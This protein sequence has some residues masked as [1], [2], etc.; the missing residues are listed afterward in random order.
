IED[1]RAEVTI[2]SESVAVEPGDA[3]GDV[4][5]LVLAA[6][7]EDNKLD[8]DLD[9]KAPA[10]GVIVAMAGLDGPLEAKLE[11]QGTWTDWNG[12]LKASWLAQ[13]LAD[14]AL[15]ARSGT[16]RAVGNTQ[17][18]GLAPDSLASALKGSSALEAE[19]ELADAST[20]IDA[21]LMGN[22]IRFEASGNV[23]LAENRFDGLRAQASL[24]GRAQVTPEV[25]GSD[26]EASI[27]LDGEISRPSIAYDL[28]AGR[29]AYADYGLEG[30]SAA[31]E[32]RLDLADMRLALNAVAERVVGLDLATGGQLR[33]VQ[34]TGDVLIEWPRIL[35]DNLRLRSQ[36]LDA[37]V[38]LAGDTQAGRYGGAIEG[39][40]GDY[41]LES[42]GLFDAASGAKFDIATSSGVAL[43]GTVQARSTRISN[44]GLQSLLGGETAISSDV[45]YQRNGVTR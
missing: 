25:S 43:E 35:S 21:R 8:L 11:G 16:F 13:P 15:T 34:L 10:G 37:G 9:L 33:N 17:L 2:N 20:R 41:R 27:V 14:L 31:G 42:V 32:T 38:T 30:F 4:M 40:L 28:R 5:R 36:R 26:L 6:V 45:Q 44:E 24:D 7:P 19:L 12:R 22:A 23:A 1:R 39:Q 29:L 3:S 18:A